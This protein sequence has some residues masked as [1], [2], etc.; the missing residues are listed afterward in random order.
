MGRVKHFEAEVHGF[1][2]VMSDKSFEPPSSPGTQR[3]NKNLCGLC[4]LRGSI[5]HDWKLCI[6]LEKTMG[7]GLQAGIQFLISTRAVHISKTIDII[8]NSLPVTNSYCFF[9]FSLYNIGDYIGRGRDYPVSIR[10]KV[11][12]PYLLL[13][14]IVAVTGAYVVTRLVSNS[15][16][17]RLSNQLLEAARGGCASDPGR[18]RIEHRK[19]DGVRPGSA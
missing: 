18:R 1:L 6:I 4:V 3:K 12:L 9:P 11:I 2:K 10:F 7:S 5:S 13:T 8:R 15:L 17:E 14:L 16:S 19:P